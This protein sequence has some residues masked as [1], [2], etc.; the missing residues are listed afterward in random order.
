M[1]T[2]Y[3]N[4]KARLLKKHHAYQGLAYRIVADDV[5]EKAKKHHFEKIIFAGF[6]AL[7]KAEEIIIEKLLDSNKAEIIWDT[8][9]YYVNNPIQEAGKF[10]RK[11]DA[12]G[13]FKKRAENNIVIAEDLL[14]TEQ[15]TFML[16]V[17][18]KTLHKQK[19]QV[20]SLPTFKPLPI[21]YKKRLWYWPMKIYYSPFCILYQKIY[22]TLTLQWVIRSE[23][24]QLQAIL[25]WC[26]TYMKMP[27]PS[28]KEKQIIVF[29]IRISLSCWHIRI[30][31]LHCIAK[32]IA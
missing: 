20:T 1:G 15:K 24:R 4:F 14:S 25:S 16:L 27:K 17:Q 10:Y 31:T 22:K 13:R 12:S 19:L 21:I 2:Y 32:K 29:T 8:D 5:E 26:L 23:I 3:E 30:P 11:H 9:N 7:N 6:N 28:K 18:L